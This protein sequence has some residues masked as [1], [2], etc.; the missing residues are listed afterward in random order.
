[1]R[2]VLL[3]LLLAS[4]LGA[5]QE[6]GTYFFSGLHQSSE[7]NPAFDADH[8]IVIA[9][10]SAFAS[11]HQRGISVG[12]FLKGQLLDLTSRQKNQIMFGSNLSMLKVSY[13]HKNIRY[14]L[15]HNY[16]SFSDFQFSNPLLFLI[17]RGNAD[18]IG[19]KVEFSPNIAMTSYSET[20]FGAT[21]VGAFSF[22]ANFKFLNGIQNLSSSRSA[23]DLSVNDD[24]YQLEM[25]ADFLLNSSFPIDL[26]NIKSVDLLRFNFVPRNFGVALDLGASYKNGPFSIAASALDLGYIRWNEQ[27]HNYQTDGRFV[28]E[29]VEVNDILEGDFNFLDTIGGSLVFTDAAQSYTNYVP[30]KF[31]ANVNYQY[32]PNVQ[33]GALV[34]AHS[35]YEHTNAAIALN[36]QR[37]WKQK[38]AVALQYAVVG[39][40]PLN[41]GVSGYT[42]LGP[43]QIYGVFDNVIGMINTLGAENSNFRIGMNLV[44]SEEPKEI[45]AHYAY[46]D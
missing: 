45:K 21:Y 15:A 10:P 30:A 29:G 25:N 31:Y 19:G 9:L 6:L 4:T 41:F 39:N 42:T 27:P 36:V 46:L 16:R 35:N 32:T 22:G 38:H 28:Y 12:S 7:L 11:F 26:N 20:V 14:N 33:F 13:K 34:Y 2:K 44:F 24:I 18:I 40:N 5:Q 8:K 1:M 37:N 43:L 17:A 3:F 23:F